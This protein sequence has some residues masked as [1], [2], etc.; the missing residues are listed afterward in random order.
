MHLLENGQ[1]IDDAGEVDVQIFTLDRPV[2]RQRIFEASTVVLP[3][4]FG[5]SRRSRGSFGEVNVHGI[6]KRTGLRPAKRSLL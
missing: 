5:L 3:N 6:V 4:V 2:I 1:G